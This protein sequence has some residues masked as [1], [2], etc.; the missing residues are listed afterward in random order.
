MDSYCIRKN[1]E[2]CLFLQAGD[3]KGLQ[4]QTDSNN[5]VTSVKWKKNVL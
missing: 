5:L 3:A 1:L 4:G 2:E